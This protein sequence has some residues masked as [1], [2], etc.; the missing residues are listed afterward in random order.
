MMTLPHLSDGHAPITLHNLFR[1][2]LFAFDDW[3]IGENEPVVESADGVVSIGE[4]FVHMR[5]C[6]DILPSHLVGEI[7]DRLSKPWE[8]DGPLNE[9]TFGTAARMMSVLVRQNRMAY[10]YLPRV[11]VVQPGAS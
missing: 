3:S 6:T 2:A 11:P 9:M 5:G 8:G 1:E 10:R 7:T 4:I